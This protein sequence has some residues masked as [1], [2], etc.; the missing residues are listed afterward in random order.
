M[1]I[2][3][4]MNLVMHPCQHLGAEAKCSVTVSESACKLLM[5]SMCLPIPVVQRIGCWGG[6]LVLGRLSIE[7]LHHVAEQQMQE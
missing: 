6:P 3:T 2:L 1:C 5:L 4:W 7:G